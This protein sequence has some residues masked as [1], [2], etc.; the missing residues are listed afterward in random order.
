MFYSYI[1]EIAEM[2]KRRRLK[3]K[4]ELS[5]GREL[6]ACETLIMKAVWDTGRDISLMGLK[7]V[8]KDRFGKDYS[9][10]L[11]VRFLLRL[12]KGLCENLPKWEKL[13]Y[14]SYKK[15]KKTIKMA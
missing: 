14:S 7:S 6:S 2:A 9:E 5:W 3:W 1:L 4:K 12:S 11:S 10:R 8:L 15:K 13:L